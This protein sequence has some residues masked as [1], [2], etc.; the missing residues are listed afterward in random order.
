M[1]ARRASGQLGLDEL[2]AKEAKVAAYQI[3]EVFAW[4]GEKDRA[5]EWLAR[6]YNQQD[7]GLSLIKTDPLLNSLRLDP[8]F[9][10][11]LRKLKL[12]E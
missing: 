4:R 12:P 2:I 8:R 10:A 1:C 5:F 6:A 9:N 7:G 3:A 11:L